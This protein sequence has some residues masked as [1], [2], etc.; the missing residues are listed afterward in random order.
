MVG[1]RIDISDESSDSDTQ[2]LSI[3]EIVLRQIRKIADISC[4]EFTG[5]Y[6]VKKPVKTGSGVMFSEV[7]HEDVREAYCNAVDFLIDLVYPLSDAD[8]KK[9]L[10][11]FEGC[12]E[13]IIKYDRKDKKQVEEPEEVDDD[14][15]IKKKIKLK[16]QSFR[17]IN[18]M[19]ERNN[20]WK[21]TGS[22]NE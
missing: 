2:V 15:K 12:K 10:E 4:K 9:Y 1:D 11:T 14:V 13:K 19:F 16:R 3:K 20:F 21:G 8:M 22:Y 6:W 17:Q 18:I 7:Y 5:G